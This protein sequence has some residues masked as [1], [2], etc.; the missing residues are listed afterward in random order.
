MKKKI[1]LSCSVVMISFLLGAHSHLS[2]ETLGIQSEEVP[3]INISDESSG[4][5][6]M[7]Q[8]SDDT[9]TSSSETRGSEQG[10]I[11]EEDTSEEASSKEEIST[12]PST[13]ESSKI[14]DSTNKD[15]TKTQQKV[16]T[17]KKEHIT[18]YRLYNKRNMEHLYTTDKNEMTTLLKI[19]NSDWKYEGGTWMSPKTAG[20]SVY[21]VYNPKSGE[22]LYTKDSYEAKVLSSKYSWKNEGRKFF[23]DNSGISVYRL[24]NPQAGIGAHFVTR[25]AYEKKVLLSKGWKYEGI[26]WKSSNTPLVVD[27]TP[28]K[29]PTT[30]KPYIKSP[31]YFSQLNSRW[32]NVPLNNSRVGISGCVPTSLAMVFKGSY[33]MNV[34]PGT[35]AIRA[36]GISHQSFGLSGKDLLNTVKAYGHSVEQI[37]NKNRA[38]TLLK[39]GYPLVFYINVGIGHAVVVYGYNNGTVNVFDPYNRQFYPSGRASLTSIWN[40]PSADPMD[41]DAGRP[42]FAVK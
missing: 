4:S 6:E 2:A 32:S 15:N 20:T 28:P 38:I 16:T 29:T 25:D 17:E 1:I 42:V 34:D 27:Y 10:Q 13:G 24:F 21:R 35:V 36:D 9:T 19:M 22:H 33:G 26:A 8:S 39:S 5:S 11:L 3:N 31:V 30:P 14:P 41:W 37:S 40:K 18:V 12:R 23:S 7:Q